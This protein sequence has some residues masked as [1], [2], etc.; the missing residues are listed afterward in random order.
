MK[1]IVLLVLIVFFV[2]TL[3]AQVPNGTYVPK[4]DMAKQMPYAKFVFSGSKVNVYLGINGVSLGVAYEYSY[5]LN[6]NMLTMK[7]GAVS[8]EFTYNNA[9]DEISLNMDAAYELLGELG[10]AFS[11]MFGKEMSSQQVSNE[12]KRL[13]P[14]VPV[15]GKEG[16]PYEPPTQSKPTTPVLNNAENTVCGGSDYTI[17]W[18][19]VANVTKYNI[20]YE[21][22]G[23]KSLSMWD[24][25]INNEWTLKKVQNIDGKL[26]IKISAKNDSGESEPLIVNVQVTKVPTL[27]KPEKI[28][29][30][31]STSKACNTISFS[32]K[33]VANAQFY[34]V[35]WILKGNEEKG[36]SFTTY[37][38]STEITL[39]NFAV[40]GINNSRDM[41]FNVY[42]CSSFC[43]Q[44][45]QSNSPAQFS[46][47]VEGIPQPNQAPDG[48]VF[49]KTTLVDT[50]LTNQDIKLIDEFLKIGGVIKL[51]GKSS[52]DIIRSEKDLDLVV[53][54]LGEE[55][56]ILGTFSKLSDLLEKHPEFEKGLKHFSY[57]YK[58]VKIGKTVYDMT[59]YF[60]D[61]GDWAGVVAWGLCEGVKAGGKIVL[62]KTGFAAGCAVG[63]ALSGAFAPIGCAI[64]GTITVYTVNKIFDN[65]IGSCKERFT[66]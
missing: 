24:E 45:V 36:G 63:S 16:V 15:W 27:A 31:P 26:T 46:V 60:S 43:N 57:F 40:D 17:S 38:T 66:E 44:W 53:T 59:D 18:K 51:L 29:D 20:Y 3:S 5:T 19:S 37:N 55:G 11:S 64:G 4:T 34:I 58:A 7:D 33:P 54:A 39:P 12:I 42:A 25:T 9:K 30:V 35:N 50:K 41:T 10:A 14:D 65:M 23:D 49:C 62:S 32:W 21:Y 47:K 56:K 28:T 48:S 6:G 22:N 13:V 61:T 2:T 8:V 1:K 52:I